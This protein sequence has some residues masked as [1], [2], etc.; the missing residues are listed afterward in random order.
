MNRERCKPPLPD[1]DVERIARSIGR[2][3]PAPMDADAG[4]TKELA[5]AITTTDSFARDKGTLLYH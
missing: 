5:S 2:K 1:R 3:E 4:L